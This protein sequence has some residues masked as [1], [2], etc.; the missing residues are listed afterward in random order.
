MILWVTDVISRKMVAIPVYKI[1]RFI[2]VNGV[3]TQTIIELD[4]LS[5]QECE[6]NIVPLTNQYKLLMENKQ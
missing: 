3:H 2:Q 1:S 6:E 5:R 4:N